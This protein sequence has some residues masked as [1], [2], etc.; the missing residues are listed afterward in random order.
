MPSVKLWHEVIVQRACYLLLRD[1]WFRQRPL[2]GLR[3]RVL[4]GVL[5]LLEHTE[6]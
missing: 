1:D 3:P 6:R 2:S 5:R 4:P